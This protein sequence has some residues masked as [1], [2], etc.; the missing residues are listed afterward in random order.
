MHFFF[1]LFFPPFSN[2]SPQGCTSWEIRNLSTPPRLSYIS[3]FLNF[4][5]THERM[6]ISRPFHSHIET[7]TL[8]RVWK[9]HNWSTSFLP[10]FSLCVCS[11]SACR[12]DREKEKQS[13]KEICLLNGCQSLWVFEYGCEES[14]EKGGGGGG[15]EIVTITRRVQSYA[16]LGLEIVSSVRK[17]SSAFKFRL[18]AHSYEAVDSYTGLIKYW[19]SR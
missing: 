3:R 10:R 4:K 15:R 11:C 14:I 1:S 13:T 12:G 8:L 2:S 5:E 19:K 17:F 6:T 7:H 18:N 9:N 16:G